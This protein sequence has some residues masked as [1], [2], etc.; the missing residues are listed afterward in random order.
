M[1]NYA[2]KLALWHTKTFKPIM[3]HDELEPIMSTLGFIGLSPTINNGTNGN[4]S[5]WKEYVFTG[6]VSDHHHKHFLASFMS[7]DDD[8][9]EK[10]KKKNNSSGEETV[11]ENNGSNKLRLPYPRIDGLHLY[12]YHAFCDSLAF[13]IGERELSDHFHVRGMPLHRTL[14]RPF[15]RKFIRMNEDDLYVYRDGTLDPATKTLYS[16]NNSTIDDSSMERG[17]N[18]KMYTH[19]GNNNI[20]I[21]KKTGIINIGSLVLLKDIIVL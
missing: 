4:G 13:Y 1:E 2:T 11:L 7:S 5:T 21:H 6:G 9:D 16:D 18:N 20:I 19:R 12:T 14:D 3:T 17:N 10:K 8:D 15:D